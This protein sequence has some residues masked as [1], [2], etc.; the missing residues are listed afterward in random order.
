MLCSR[1]T[2]TSDSLAS[3]VFS[4]HGVDA[5]LSTCLCKLK[6]KK[7]KPWQFCSTRRFLKQMF[8]KSETDHTQECQWWRKPPKNC[9]SYSPNPACALLQCTVYG[10]H[11]PLWRHASL[12]A[13]DMEWWGP[14][15]S[16][17]L[18]LW[19]ECL[20]EPLTYQTLVL[21]KR[22]ST[23]PPRLHSK[24]LEIP[25]GLDSNGF[26]RGHAFINFITETTIAK[27]HR[28][29]AMGTERFFILQ[30]LNN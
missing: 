10:R 29:C 17:S 15:S 27:I 19:V 5:Y 4:V 1:K 2:D 25:S 11:S 26:V 24:Q 30:I 18:L 28:A 21:L 6:K 16:P 23:C 7:I 3:P 13:G 12:G 9:I 20:C 22:G 14:L 8:Q